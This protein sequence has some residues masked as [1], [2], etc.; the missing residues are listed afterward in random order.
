MKVMVSGGAGFIGSHITELLFQSGIEVIVVD[1]LS[2]GDLGNI[3]E[4]V[5]F[6]KISINDPNLEEVFRK[7]RPTHIIH[8]AAQTKVSES[9]Y[10]PINDSM[11]NIIGTLNIVNCAVKYKCAKFIYASS[12]AIYGDSKVMPLHEELEPIPVSPYGISKFVPELY[13]KYYY[14]M[15][16]LPFT[17]LRYSNVYGNR[18]SVLL[19][20]GVVAIFIDKLLSNQSIKIFGDGNQTRDFVYVKDIAEANILALSHGNNQTLNIS[21]RKSISINTLV[22]CLESVYHCK[23]MAEYADE[24]PGD[25][26]YSSMDNSRAHKEIGWVPKYDLLAGLKDMTSNRQQTLVR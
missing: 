17:I 9:I 7:E 26:Y 6:Y 11:T 23:A 1:D 18:Q 8:H 3:P 15:Y 16:G 10:N 13:L 20:G 5:S 22:T 25:I 19:D 21:T 4:S 2:G 24:R 12:A 14:K